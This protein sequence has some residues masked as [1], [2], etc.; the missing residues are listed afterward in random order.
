MK[1]A[2][3]FALCF[4]AFGCSKHVTKLTPDPD[5]PKATEAPVVIDLA[6][7]PEAQPAETTRPVVT[8]AVTVYFAF[9]SDVLTAT[10]LYKLSTVKG[11]VGLTGHCSPEGSESYNLALG[12]RRALAVKRALRACNVA[13]CLS[14]G[15][16][17][18]ITTDPARYAENR[19]CEVKFER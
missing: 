5:A 19:R 14:A 10:E 4:L 18:L 2:L 15:K 11:T 17:Q 13:S 16:R 7:Q 8:Q 1:L 3:V 9:D 12:Y 6:G